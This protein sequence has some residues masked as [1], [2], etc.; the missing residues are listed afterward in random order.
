MRRLRSFAFLLV[1]ALLAVAVGGAPD[2]RAL[3]RLHVQTIELHTA[4]I[5]LTFA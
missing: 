2:A 3:T 4:P 5:A 1:A